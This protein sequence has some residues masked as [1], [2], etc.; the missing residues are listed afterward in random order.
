MLFSRVGRRQ[1]VNFGRIYNISMARTQAAL[2]LVLPR[3]LARLAHSYLILSAHP[4]IAEIGFSGHGEYY[5]TLYCDIQFDRACYH[6]YPALAEHAISEGQVDINRGLYWAC[7]GRNIDIVKLVVRYGANDWNLA[8]GGACQAKN[9]I[10]MRMM[11]GN[12]ATGCTNCC[13]TLSNHFVV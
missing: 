5:I 6:G 13:R 10:L 3:D 9:V 2:E 7:V 1:N 8:L 4:T 11:I 12:G